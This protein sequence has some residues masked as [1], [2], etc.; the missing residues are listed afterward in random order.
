VDDNI[1]VFFEKTEVRRQ[2]KRGV[3]KQL[4]K[5]P[6]VFF[7]PQEASPGTISVTKRTFYTAHMMIVSGNTARNIS[8]IHQI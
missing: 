3:L 8:K 7:L 5:P 2:Q 6:Q 4:L 1:I